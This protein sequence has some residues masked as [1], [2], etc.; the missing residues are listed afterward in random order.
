MVQKLNGLMRDA[1]LINITKQTFTAPFGPLG[2]AG[3]LFAEDY[4]LLSSSTQLLI[5]SVFNVPKVKVKKNCTLMVEE[6]KSHQ[7][8]MTIPVCLG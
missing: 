8:Y 1:D 3:E 4:K 5:T 7:A 2:G 6:F